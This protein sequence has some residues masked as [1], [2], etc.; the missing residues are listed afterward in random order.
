M[1]RLADEMF[2][3]MRDLHEVG[4]I[5]SD[6]MNEFTALYKQVPKY[7]AEKVK[8]IRAKTS[9][10]QTTFAKLLNVSPSSVRQWESG[11]KKPDGASRKL[12]QLLE[13]HGVAYFLA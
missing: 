2:E 1:S 11:A 7:D 3:T 4:A 12:L 5:S 8:E 10:S 13:T 9:F 6:R